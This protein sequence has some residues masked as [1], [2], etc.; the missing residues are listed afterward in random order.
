ML[1]FDSININFWLSFSAHWLCFAC[2]LLLPPFFDIQIKLIL[3]NSRHHKGVSVCVPAH[4]PPDPTASRNQHVAD[5]ILVMIS[6]LSFKGLTNQLCIWERISVL[7][8]GLV[9]D[10]EREFNS[11][12][13]AQMHCRL[14]MTV[15]VFILWW[16]LDASCVLND[17]S[18]SSLF[19]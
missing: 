19:W 6:S 11:W 1:W 15:E 3:G 8:K 2:I 18:P 9:P 10:T 13:L 4:S 12:S 14:V 16:P 7:A 17:S 5:F